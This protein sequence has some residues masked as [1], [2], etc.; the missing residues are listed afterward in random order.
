MK[1]PTFP[2]LLTDGPAIMRPRRI[3]PGVKRVGKLVT[4]R[5]VLPEVLT[6]QLRRQQER[7]A[8]KGRALI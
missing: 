3:G 5:A 4:K 2:P 8:L 7:L 1:L 6:R